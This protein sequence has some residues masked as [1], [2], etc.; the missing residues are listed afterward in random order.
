MKSARLHEPGHPLKVE[1]IPVPKVGPGDV[2]I[3]VRAAGICGT[4]LHIQD[5]ELIQIPGVEASNMELPIVLGHEISGTVEEV[6][7]SISDFQI[8]DRVLVDP[9]IS[10]GRCYYCIIG[11]YTLCEKRASYGESADGGFEEYVCIRKENVYKF[12]SDIDFDEAAIL[13][14]SLATPFHA[15]ERL[16]VQPGDSV[17]LFGIGGLGMNAVQLAKLRGAYVFAIDVLDEKLKIAKEMG[18]DVV[19]NAR[20]TD[21]AI[22]IKN[23]T[24]GRGADCSIE[25]VGGRVTIEAAI[26]SVRRGGKVGVV[27]GS[28][29]E[30]KVGIRQLLWNDITIYA[31]FG[32]LKPYLP[33]MLSLLSMKKINLKRMITNRLALEDVNEGFRILREKV[34][35][36]IRVVLIP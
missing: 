11:A 31:C 21:P 13:T 3:R 4:D 16:N 25:M 26:R 27:G 17:A 14:D 34:D 32:Q 7:N 10:C 2:L 29:E 1:Q 33:R 19:I 36:P 24:S 22:R 12:S 20:E 30:F 23:L 35:N 6:E 18:A 28:N 5:G 8:G 9:A 15:L